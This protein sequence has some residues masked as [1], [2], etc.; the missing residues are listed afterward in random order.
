MA[1]YNLR[2]DRVTPVIG[3]EIEGV[4]LS[5]ALDQATLDAI[6]EALLEH[7]VIFFRD[8]QLSADSHVRFA[9]TFG[10][11]DQPHPI[12]P[13]VSGHPEVV[14][15]EN[16]NERPPDTNDWHTD[17][18]FKSK[19]PFAS[20]LFADTVPESGGD[21]MWANMYAAYNALPE[22]IQGLLADLSA[23]HDMGDFRNTYLAQA[24]GINKLNA[25]MTNIGSVLHPVV[26]RHPVTDKPYLYVN[27]SFTRH[28]ANMQW[29]ES[30]RLLR[31]LFDHINCPEFQ[32]RFRWKP[33]SVAMWDNRV[34]QHYAVADYLPHHRR[35]HRVT[36]INDRRVKTNA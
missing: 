23:V 8:Q 5:Q 12:Y 9:K 19:P 3:A 34:T 16:D 33:G 14:L 28:I 30:D 10:E 15:L 32:V 2:V 22:H 36:V 1:S 21:T 18:T 20:I 4:D 6:Y 26:E 35:M 11:L 7:L 13:H 24:D 27:A 17:L 29:S 31:Y 25:A